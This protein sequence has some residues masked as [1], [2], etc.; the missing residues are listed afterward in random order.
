MPEV[1]TIRS[2]KRRELKIALN[3]PDDATQK[4]INE[5]MLEILKE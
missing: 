3:L 5:A 4:E 1:N 2:S